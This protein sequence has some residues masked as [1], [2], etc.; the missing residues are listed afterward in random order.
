MVFSINHYL[1]QFPTLIYNLTQF[2]DASI[3]LSFI[4]ILIIYVPRLWESLLSA[5]VLSL[6]FSRLLKDIFLVPRPAEILN[7]D[8]FII[9]GKTL[10]GFSSL[11]SGHSVT[12][13]T[14]LTILLF[15]FMPKT[16]GYKIAWVFLFITLGLLLVI[17]RVG[18][19]AHF[20]L[21]V[22]N[23]SIVGY[24]CG[25]SGIFISRKYKICCWVNEKKYYLLFVVAII[26]CSIS[27]LIKISN[28]NLFV[29]Y[30]AL[31]SLILSLYKFIY[32][33]FKK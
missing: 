28:D 20:P 22:I 10:H 33:Y 15:A 5:L 8:S 11:P 30:L 29:Y 26:F 9:I 16:L 14:I 19:G 3:F 31:I 32:V 1:G 25:I 24:L 17:T 2:G 7:H 4:I 18:I 6:V 23:G 21:D 27:L 12:V 13:F